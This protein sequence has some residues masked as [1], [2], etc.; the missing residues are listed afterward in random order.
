MSLRKYS[1][2]P[3]LNIQRKVTH[4]SRLFV[5]VVHA[6]INEFTYLRSYTKCL[7]GDI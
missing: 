7:G 3:M 4:M 6:L 1:L 2:L 5:F